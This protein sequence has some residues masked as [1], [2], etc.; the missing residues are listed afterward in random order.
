M[1]RA[2]A[3]VLLMMKD[4]LEEK[5]VQSS[6]QATGHIGNHWNNL[7][8]STKDGQKTL[9]QLQDTL[10]KV[11][12]SVGVLD[13]GRKHLRLKGV[14]E[15]IVMFQQQIRSYPDTIQLSLQTVIL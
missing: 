7:S 5:K 13:G 14:A 12:K 4:T 10:D 15:E 11:N 3:Q 6:L 2:F 9:I 8:T 1:L